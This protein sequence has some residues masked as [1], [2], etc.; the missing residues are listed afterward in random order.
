MFCAIVEARCDKVHSGLGGQ[1]SDERRD[2][3]GANHNS[4]IS[5]RTSWPVTRTNIHWGWLVHDRLHG[6]GKL[7]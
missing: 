7:I 3:W 2:E 5:L 6:F 4:T 1:R